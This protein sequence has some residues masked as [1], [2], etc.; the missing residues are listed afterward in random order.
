MRFTAGILIL[1]A[2]CGCRRTDGDPVVKEARKR[3]PILELE[4]IGE[5]S[6]PVGQVIVVSSV[7]RNKTEDAVRVTRVVSDCACRSV[8]VSFRGVRRAAHRIGE[9]HPLVVPPDGVGVVELA[10]PVK[11][12]DTRLSLALYGSGGLPLGQVAGVIRGEDAFRI[13]SDGAS[14]DRLDL[15]TCACGERVSRTVEVQ[16]ESG[17]SVLVQSV[18]SSADWAYAKVVGMSR[19]EIGCTVPHAAGQILREELRIK[20]AGGACISLPVRGFVVDRVWVEPGPVVQLGIISAGEARV[21]IKAKSVLESAP[22]VK[23]VRL[24]TGIPEH[25]EYG[26]RLS[27]KEDRLGAVIIAKVEGRRVGSA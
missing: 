4:D 25:V 1:L 13:R 15:G 5:L 22:T 8:D 14:V 26:L 2:C 23:A 7:L 17:R 27:Q 21:E 16:L 3:A 10:I 20:I 19:V 6:F 24:R 18:S 12:G 11:Q 9:D